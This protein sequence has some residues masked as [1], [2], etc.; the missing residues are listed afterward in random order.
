MELSTTLIIVAVI[1]LLIIG[2]VL[3]VVFSPSESEKTVIHDNKGSAQWA[4]SIG[5]TTA[6]YPSV[7]TDKEGNVYLFGVYNEVATINSYTKVESGNI[8]L[9]PYGTL[10]YSATPGNNN[11]VLVKYNSEGRVQWATSIVGNLGNDCTLAID[12]LGNIYLC[13]DF[14]PS[15]IN[16][17]NSSSV[18]EGTINVS[19]YGT[20][21]NNDE[22]TR[23]A[24]LVKYDTEGQAQW[25][26]IISGVSTNPYGLYVATDTSNNVYVTGI[27]VTDPVTINNSA[28]PSTPGGAIPVTAY[29]TLANTDNADVFL[30]KYSASGQA[31]WA[32]KISNSV[33]TSIF[34]DKFN[35]LYVAGSYF[36][37]PASAINNF[38]SAPPTAGGEVGVSLFGNLAVS[39]NGDNNIFLAKYM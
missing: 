18:S 3:F 39:A 38:A 8:Q 21:T 34:V 4:T 12:T 37:Y 28:T 13:G 35:S 5:A 23:G 30:V 2:I 14:S 7:A 10:A 31:Q 15:S 22:E 36:G 33:V 26:T 25:A 1:I 27:Y 24:F 6:G 32:T 19:L 11:N 29:G 16:I 17:N 20:L 9:I